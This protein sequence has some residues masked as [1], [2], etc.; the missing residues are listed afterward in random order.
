MQACL[1]S[2]ETGMLKLQQ[3]FNEDLP[4][5]LTA[6]DQDN[7]RMA[8]QTKKIDDA[9]MTAN[10]EVKNDTDAVQKNSRSKL[11]VIGSTVTQYNNARSLRDTATYS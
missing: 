2:E 5:I 11:L 8:M 6:D 1:H 9:L 3:I 7:E 10:Q 4:N